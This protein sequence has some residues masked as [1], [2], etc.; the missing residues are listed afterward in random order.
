MVFPSFYCSMDLIKP[1]VPVPFV[2]SNPNK[3][4]SITIM[5]QQDFILQRTT[6]LQQQHQDYHLPLDIIRQTG[7]PDQQDLLVLLQPIK[8]RVIY[9]D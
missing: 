3:S 8:Y 9:M 5:L 4:Q 1:P 6:G 7:Y 2:Y